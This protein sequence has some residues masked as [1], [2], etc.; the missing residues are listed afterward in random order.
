MDDTV[1]LGVHLVLRESKLCAVLVERIDLLTT[2]RIRNGLV[3]I[4]GLDIMIRHE[5]VLLRA[6]DFQSALAQTVESLRRSDLMSIETVDVKLCGT[7]FDNL[8]NV[9]VPN[10]IK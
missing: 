5:E 10:L 7:V 6:E 8:H 3:L 4:V 1:V 2:Y 9:T